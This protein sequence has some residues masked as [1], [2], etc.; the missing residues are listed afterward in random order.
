MDSRAPGPFLVAS[1]IWAAANSDSQALLF[2]RSGGFGQD[3]GGFHG[4]WVGCVQGPCRPLTWRIYLSLLQEGHQRIW[5]KAG[6]GK[7]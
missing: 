1:L 4:A 3:P 5:S 7:A 6:E 2:W